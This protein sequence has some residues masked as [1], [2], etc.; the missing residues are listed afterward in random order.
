M[1]NI[2]GLVLFLFAVCVGVSAQKKEKLYHSSNEKLDPIA[3]D[4]SPIEM[5]WKKSDIIDK[6]SYARPKEALITHAE[7]DLV[8]DFRNHL[9]TGSVTYDVSFQSG[10]QVVFDTKGLI[11]E[12]VI[13]G[14]GNSLEYK[15]GLEDPLLGAPLTVLMD[16]RESTELTI[17]YSTAKE[18]ESLQWLTKEQAS[19]EQPFL[20]TQGEAILTRSWIPIQDSPGIKITYSAKVE[21]PS[22]LTCVMSAARKEVDGKVLFEM[23]K[24]IPAY[25]IAMAVGDLKFVDISEIC[26]VWG[27]PNEVENAAREFKSTPDMIIAAEKIAGPYLW[28]R[29]DMIVLPK[30]F[31]FGGM[32]NPMLTFLTPT[33]IA[34]DGSLVSLVAHELA[35]SWS[36]NLVT[37]ATWDDFWL[38]EG[39]T[40]Y[41]ERRIIEAVYGKEL[42]LMHRYNGYMNLMSTI[43]ELGEDSKDT[44]LK[45]NLAGRNPDDGMTDIAYEKGAMFLEHLDMREGREK[46]D[47]FLKAYFH[48]HRQFNAVTTSDFLGLIKD[49]Y[50]DSKILTDKFINDWVYGPGLPETW[51]AK[52]EKF[53]VIDSIISGLVFGKNLDE[54][55]LKGFSVPEW[56]YFLELLEPNHLSENSKEVLDLFKSKLYSNSEIKA[57]WFVLSIKAGYKEEDRAISDFL[58][59]VG[60]RKFLVPIYKALIEYREDQAMEKKAYLKRRGNYHSI[61]QNTLD[62]L[63]TVSK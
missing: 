8:V 26:G 63:F 16:R 40:V 61:T 59:T 44:H 58:N 34:G 24:P 15:V 7:L 52:P 14:N 56:L 5:F 30:A 18:A 12:K 17:F 2:I 60:R 33:V 13:S 41:L 31:P 46:M 57:K 50:Q 21:V 22:G 49:Y 45:L 25:L 23:A 9:V 37:N 42:F 54:A 10:N 39:V 11:I 62:Q 53:I 38:N 47:N 1:K 4:Y 51:I 27:L 3:S 19:S 48:K 35:H 36:G 6:H 55:N 28:R 32:E 29:Y 20:Y 43:I